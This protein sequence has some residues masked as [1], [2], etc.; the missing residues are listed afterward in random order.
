MA[1]T[2]GELK[3]YNRQLILRE[4]GGEGQERLRRAR[5]LVVGAG[6]LGSPAAYYLAAAGI[7]TLGIVDSDRVD[8]SNLQRQILHR[9]EDLGRP[10]VESAS[11]ALRAL[12]P[13]I[14]VKT[15]PIKLTPAN[16]METIQGYDVVIDAVDNF[17]RGSCSTMPA[18]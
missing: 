2:G 14:E 1:L 16:A 8:L 3:R 10:K 17:P 4:V 5:V 18:S 7:G 15:Y 6:G 13:L 12:N 11:R 9:T